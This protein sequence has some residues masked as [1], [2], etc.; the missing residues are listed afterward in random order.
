MKILHYTIGFHPER[1][2]GLPRYATDLMNEQVNQGYTVFAF[3]PGR[4]NFI[5]K[6][7]I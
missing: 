3:Y 4:I 7:R 2:G 1:S 5:K 6:N